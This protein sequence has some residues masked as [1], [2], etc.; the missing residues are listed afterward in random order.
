MD[1]IFRTAVVCAAACVAA[2]AGTSSPANAEVVLKFKD[3]DRAFDSGVN[4][5]GVEDRSNAS[6][7]GVVGSATGV[8][9]DR[10]NGASTTLKTV[11]IIGGDGTSAAAGTGTNNFHET[12]VNKNGLL[13]V[14][15]DQDQ[16]DGMSGEA[17]NFNPG[18]AWVFSFSSNVQLTQIVLNGFTAGE[19]K[20]RLHSAAF[21]DI[22][23][24]ANG[25]NDLNGALIAA[26]TKVTLIFD[27][28]SGDETFNVSGLSF[29]VVPEP[30]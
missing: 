10:A 13:G 28:S 11:D 23:L 2:L 19:Q 17:G 12:N 8:L 16:D 3:K 22:T 20:V 14:N 21:G 9:V 26:G 25:A 7:V 27:S 29:N 18:E 1:M 30:V 24:G 15:T 6:L 4:P 5:G